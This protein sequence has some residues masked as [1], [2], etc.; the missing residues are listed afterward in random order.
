MALFSSCVHPPPGVG[1]RPHEAEDAGH[2]LRC[3]EKSAGPHGPRFSDHPAS[4]AQSFSGIQHVGHL[5]PSSSGDQLPAKLTD[6]I[7]QCSSQVG[8]AMNNVA[9][10]ELSISRDARMPFPSPS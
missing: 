5:T 8:A 1:F 9:M 10:L 3:H 2:V 4:G 6:K 7:H